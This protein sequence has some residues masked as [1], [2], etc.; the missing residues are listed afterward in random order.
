[1]PTSCDFVCGN[2][3]ASRGA[4]KGIIGIIID[5]KNSTQNG[6]NIEQSNIN[7]KKYIIKKYKYKHYKCIRNNKIKYQY[8]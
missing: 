4:T 1:M 3:L 6:N 7:I 5:I 8:R 2:M